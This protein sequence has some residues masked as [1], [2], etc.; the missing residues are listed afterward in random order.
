MTSKEQR[1]LK[2]KNI[3]LF[4]SLSQKKLSDLEQL[5][6]AKLFPK[7]DVILQEED[8]PNYMYV[9]YSGKVKVEQLSIDGRARILAVRGE[10][11]FFGEMAILDGKTEPANVIAM[12]DSEIGLISKTIFEKFL[13]N[14]EDGLRQ[15][16][17]VL[18]SRLRDAWLMLKVYSFADAEQ[19]VRATLRFLTKHNGIEDKRGIIISQ[20][21]THQDIADYASLSR[22]TVTRILDRFSK[23]G[24]VEI[25]K[26]KNILLK[27]SFFSKKSISKVRTADFLKKL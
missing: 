3:P 9:V 2:L 12:E 23:E 26:N 24:K 1:L 19:K 25:L 21:L 10:G 8:T 15:I 7:N 16:N 4:S 20:K 27:P 22:E 5:I 14:N 11:D 17:A 18:C 13:I 6:P